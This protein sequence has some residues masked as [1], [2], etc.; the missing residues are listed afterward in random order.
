MY[1]ILNNMQ[2]ILLK[3]YYHKYLIKNQ[4]NNFGTSAILYALYKLNERCLL[5]L[6]VKKIPFT[7]VFYERSAIALALSQ[8]LSTR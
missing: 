4:L 6:E 3:S 2:T 7:S 5:R 8:A 1:N